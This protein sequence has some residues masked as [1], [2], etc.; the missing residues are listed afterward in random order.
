MTKPVILVPTDF[1]PV[2]DSAVAYAKQLSD[3][4]RKQNEYQY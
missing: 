2:G 1:T 3:M 4:R